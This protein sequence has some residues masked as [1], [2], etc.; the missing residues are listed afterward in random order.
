MKSIFKIDFN[1]DT[2]IILAVLKRFRGHKTSFRYKK[3]GN[4]S[5]V[6]L[7]N[8]KVYTAF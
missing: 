2:K 3:Y 6:V 5:T 4:Q 8:T 7:L 1:T